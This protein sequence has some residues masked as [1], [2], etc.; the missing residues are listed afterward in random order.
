MTFE[1]RLP[2]APYRF[3][4]AGEAAV[5]C[6]KRHTPLF[7]EEYYVHADGTVVVLRNYAADGSFHVLSNKGEIRLIDKANDYRSPSP[8]SV[9]LL[10]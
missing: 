6:R 3:E 10:P 2:L 5:E 4:W 8:V 7:D 9:V 1:L